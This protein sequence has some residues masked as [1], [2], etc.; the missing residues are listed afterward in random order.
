MFEAFLVGGERLGTVDA[1]DGE[2][3]A[4]LFGVSFE[5]VG[6]QVFL[7]EKPG[8]FGKETEKQTRH[9]H[10]ESVNGLGVANVIVTANI[11]KEFRHQLSRLDISFSF[12]GKLH[13]FQFLQ[14][15]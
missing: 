15:E 3:G 11:V 4:V 9:K 13:F 1:F 10:I 14:A 7:G 8:I 2:V 12:F 6:K 5:R